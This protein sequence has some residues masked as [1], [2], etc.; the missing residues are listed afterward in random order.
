MLAPGPHPPVDGLTVT[1]VA[2]RRARGRGADLRA[3][4]RRNRRRELEQLRAGAN[5]AIRITPVLDS[6]RAVHGTLLADGRE[7]TVAKR[8]TGR[9]GCGHRATTWISSSPPRSWSVTVGA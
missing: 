5:G 4:H 6:T 8:L 2:F 9:D 1:M 7:G 3:V